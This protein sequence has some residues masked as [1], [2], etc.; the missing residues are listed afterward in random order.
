MIQSKLLEL[1]EQEQ[2]EAED[3]ELRESR[4]KRAYDEMADLQIKEIIRTMR[5]YTKGT[6]GYEAQSHLASQGQV[7][8]ASAKKSSGSED[9]V[10]E[11]KD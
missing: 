7:T 2:M 10:D 11:E 3:E 5:A 6:N 4:R 8:G 9:D 1:F